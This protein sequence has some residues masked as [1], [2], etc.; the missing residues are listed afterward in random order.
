ML[1]H[2]EVTVCGSDLYGISQIPVLACSHEE[3][4]LSVL[5]QVG[6]VGDV[7]MVRVDGIEHP[8]QSYIDTYMER[9]HPGQ[10]LCDPELSQEDADRWYS[11]C[12]EAFEAIHPRVQIWTPCSY[13]T[14]SQHSLEILLE[15]A[16][17]LL[18]DMHLYQVRDLVIHKDPKLLI[19]STTPQHAAEQALHQILMSKECAGSDEVI[20]TV[21]GPNGEKCQLSSEN[22]EIPNGACSSPKPLRDHVKGGFGTGPTLASP[23]RRI[24]IRR[25]VARLNLSIQ[26]TPRVLVHDELDTLVGKVSTQSRL[27][28]I[29]KDFD[30]A[31]QSCH[32]R[33]ELNQLPDCFGRLHHQPCEQ[34]CTND[35]LV[36]CIRIRAKAENL[37]PLLEPFCDGP[38]TQKPNVE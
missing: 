24:A 29:I 30:D 22:A 23:Q 18:N 10:K 36:A 9:V 12:V 16:R 4:A 14:A 8:P 11:E 32:E 37:K 25:T 15:R 3:A 6:T 28:G 21:V 34:S 35:M 26:R 38:V 2:F 31:F 1:N 7:H 5:C 20:V 17:Q 27:W 33:W 13:S 19:F